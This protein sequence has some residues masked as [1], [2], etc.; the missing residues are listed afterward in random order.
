MVK[1]TG[2]QVDLTVAQQALCSLYRINLLPFEEFHFRSTRAE[3]LP[4]NPFP[5]NY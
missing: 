2:S 5:F 4:G 3:S 1:Q